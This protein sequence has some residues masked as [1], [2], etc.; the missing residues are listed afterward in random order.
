MMQELLEA[1]DAALLA[2]RLELDRSLL[3][4]QSL[5]QQL[6]EAESEGREMV[7]FLQ[8]E[9]VLFL[10][11]SMFYWLIFSWILVNRM[12]IGCFV[13][14]HR[15]NGFLPHSTLYGVL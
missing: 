15:R 10:V 1:Q 3:A 13:V 4:Q 9:K 7:E 11:S 8:A 12:G 2:Q 14:L 5:A 6:H